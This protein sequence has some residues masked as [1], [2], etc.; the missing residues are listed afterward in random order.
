MYRLHIRDSIIEKLRYDYVNIFGGKTVRGLFI[1]FLKIFKSLKLLKE[2][3]ALEVLKLQC[4]P[5]V[6]LTI[7][8]RRKSAEY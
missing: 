2:T 5:E 6:M 1:S 8:F 7:K 4:R 3:F